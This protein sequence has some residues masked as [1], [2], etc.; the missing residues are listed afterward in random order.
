MNTIRRFKEWA[1][2]AWNTIKRII[3][4]V[5]VTFI[6]LGIVYEVI[7]DQIFIEIA[8]TIFALVTSFCLLWLEKWLCLQTNL[9]VDRKNKLR[10]M[11]S[12]FCNLTI[13]FLLT[14]IGAEGWQLVIGTIAVFLL[15]E[16]I[17]I[18]VAWWYDR[19]PVEPKVYE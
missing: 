17:A 3:V 18:A 16:A 2:R 7:G 4:I 6:V 12:V 10:L 15:L 1:G 14:W 11:I 5:V 8:Y 9:Q 13:A 19:V